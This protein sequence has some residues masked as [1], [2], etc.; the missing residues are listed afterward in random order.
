MAETD[1]D[2]GWLDSA[3]DFFGVT[4]AGFGVLYASGG[5]KGDFY[6]KYEI[7]YNIGLKADVKLPPVFSGSVE[8]RPTS[9]DGGSLRVT[10][11]AGLFKQEFTYRHTTNS[12]GMVTEDYGFKVK[13]PGGSISIFGGVFTDEDTALGSVLSFS[14]DTRNWKKF[15]KFVDMYAEYVGAPLAAIEKGIGLG[16]EVPPGGLQWSLNFSFTLRADILSRDLT[17]QV[18]ESWSDRRDRALGTPGEPGYLGDKYVS[19]EIVNQ[20]VNSYASG[21][22]QKAAKVLV[23]GYNGVAITGDKNFYPDAILR[24]QAGYEGGTG[25]GSTL[26]SKSSGTSS[27]KKQES[28]ADKYSGSGGGGGDSGKAGSAVSSKSTSSSKNEYGYE[29]TTTTTTYKSGV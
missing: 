6:G 8:Y 10:G 12:Q 9:W 7:S 16:A 18:G 3:A 13:S 1:V 26:I 28:Y 27:T 14:Y 15:S 4:G 11:G 2:Y 19:S 23:S 25:S 21:D 24:K 20:Y 22:L 5:V 29:K 17:P